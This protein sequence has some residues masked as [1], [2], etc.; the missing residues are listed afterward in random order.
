[1]NWIYI[2]LAF[3]VHDADGV[4]RRLKHFLIL[5]DLAIFRFLFYL[6]G[7]FQTT[8][9]FILGVQKKALAMLLIM[10]CNTIVIYIFK[11]EI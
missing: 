3:T 1:M 4:V 10:L 6:L 7:A 8:L 2:S 11:W 9:E 5:L